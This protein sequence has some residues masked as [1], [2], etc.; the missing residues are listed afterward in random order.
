MFKN[1]GFYVNYFLSGFRNQYRG[2]MRVSN[3]RPWLHIERL[4]RAFYNNL[5]LNL[6]KLLVF[7]R[8]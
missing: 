2:L 3:D 6:L 1:G 7:G 4:L 5:L 8:V